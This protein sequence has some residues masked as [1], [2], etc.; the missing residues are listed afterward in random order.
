MMPDENGLESEDEFIN[1]DLIQRIE[2]HEEQLLNRSE[3]ST[4]GEVKSNERPLNSI[5]VEEVEFPLIKKEWP[6]HTV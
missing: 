5:I 6:I 4:K 1:K 3:W 2:K